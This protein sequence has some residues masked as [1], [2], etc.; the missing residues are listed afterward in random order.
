MYHFKKRLEE[1]CPNHAYPVRHKLKDCGM[2]R[3]FMT[4]GSLTC[5]AELNEGPDGSDT[6]SFPKVNAVMT[7]YGRW[8]SSGRHRVSSLSPWTPTHCS[9]GHG[10]LGL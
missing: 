2:M 5:S 10:G 6:L 4:T 3:S 1:A 7:V 9:R 8:P